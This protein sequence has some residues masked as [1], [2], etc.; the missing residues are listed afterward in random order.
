MIR[1]GRLRRY[2]RRLRASV[3]V[4]AAVFGLGQNTA[5]AVP[6][7]DLF[8]GGSITAVDKLFSNWQ[9]LGTNIGDLSQIDVT[10]LVDQPDNPGIRFTDN[11]DV[12]RVAGGPPGSSFFLDFSY[13]VTVLNPTQQITDN[14]LVLESF[15]ING[16]DTGTAGIE[17]VEFVF[18]SGNNQQAFKRVSALQGD[19]NIVDLANFAPQ[20]SL[21]V[22]TSVNGFVEGLPTDLA[23]LNAFSQRFSQ[24]TI[25]VM[26][27]PSTLAP[28]AIGLVGLGAMVRRR[29]RE[30]PS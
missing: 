13:T 3:I 21:L 7:T 12:W 17:I 18:D 8:A 2:S 24:T 26:P 1:L 5:Q 15:S 29:R 11:G 19:L 30:Q 10:T 16:L 27:E 14:S 23:E 4:V 28:F 6:L 20:P 9:N 22:T 25:S